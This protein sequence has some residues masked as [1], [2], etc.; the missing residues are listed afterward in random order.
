MGGVVPPAPAAE[1]AHTGN[2]GLQM[3]LLPADPPAA[4]W[5]WAISQT[6][7]IPGDASKVTLDW[8]YRADDDGVPEG[9]LLVTAKG[10]ASTLSKT[11]SLDVGG[12]THDWLD[13]TELAGQE[14]IVTLRFTRPVG[15][16]ESTLWLDEVGLGI[17]GASRLFLPLLMRSQ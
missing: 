12:W 15:Q 5:T 8:M 1:A 17:G 16:Q 2:Y 4:P 14:A 3:G 6:V 13:V 10:T 11:S 7:T 9:E